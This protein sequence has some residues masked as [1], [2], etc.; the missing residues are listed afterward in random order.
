MM[1]TIAAVAKPKS[2][3]LVLILASTLF[4]SAFLLFWCE[5]MVGKMVLPLAG[6]TAA[7]WTT[8]LLFFQ[9]MLLAAYLYAHLLGRL[10]DIRQQF[11]IHALVLAVPLAFLPIQFGLGPEDRIPENPVL[12]L[13]LRLFAGAG[14]PFFAL[15]TT[16]PLLQNWFST[17][18]EDSATDPYFLYAASNV[19]SLSA[20]LIHPF[21]LEPVFG[22]SRQS[23]YW[24]IGYVVLM[25]MVLVGAVGVVRHLHGELKHPEFKRHSKPTIRMRAYWITASLLP[26]ALMLAVTNHI[27]TNMT[28]APFV[29]VIPLAVYLLTF[30]LA[31]AR[32]GGV[33]SARASRAMPL[34]LLLLLI[35]PAIAAAVGSW[36]NWL[37]MVIHVALLFCAALLCHAGLAEHRPGA[38][39]LTEFY[40]WVALGGVL[41]GA[42]TAIVA[43]LIFRTIFE[44]PLLVVMILFLRPGSR[45]SEI[46]RS[47]LSKWALPACIGVIAGVAFIVLRWLEISS[48][49]RALPIAIV[50]LTLA[51]YQLRTYPRAFATICAV[52]ILANTI[53]L[54]KYFDADQRLYVGRNFFG[55]KAVWEDPKHNLRTFVHGN[56][57]HGVENTTPDLQGRP[58]AYFH[59]TGPVGDVIA[60]LDQK[61][62]QQMGILGLGAGS[63]AAYAGPA[64]PITFFEIDPDVESIARRFFTFLDR[65]AEHCKVI[66]GDGRLELE[67]LPAGV[68]DLLMM[69]AFSSDAVPAHLISREAIELYLSKLAPGGIL[70]FNSTNRFLDVGRLVSELVTDAGLVAFERQDST[71][72]LLVD[73]KLPSIFVVAA[74]DIR[75]LRSLPERP[76]WKRLTRSASFRVWTDDYSSLLP[77]LRLQ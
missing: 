17:T 41:G 36:S 69:D 13:L 70:L 58:L 29:W 39:N 46:S 75:D 73:G 68:F 30:I 32:N 54:P 63:M 24:F 47:Q 52:G 21:V 18:T 55:A 6:G 27:A 25:V 9:I 12:W 48:G 4:V 20:L 40:L 71:G 14:L 74:R 60:V 42:F 66:I 53:V 72:D 57:R 5:P 59:Q 28:S 31:F 7:V 62:S 56:T 49:D 37:L 11:V 50:M 19:G 67:R 76:G 43:P 45:L 23:R 1:S 10:R 64:R 77:I 3:S 22:A 26:S 33:S 51:V 15:A 34:M 65:C 35:S 61:Q 8:C 38:E 2:S 16:A 44:Y